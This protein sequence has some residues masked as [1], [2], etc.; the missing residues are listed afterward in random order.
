M[1]D[2]EE[3]SIMMQLPIEV[4]NKIYCDFLFS[5]FL[6]TFRETLQ[7]MKPGSN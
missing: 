4:Q 5:E 7:I 1:D 3:M 2:P 6:S